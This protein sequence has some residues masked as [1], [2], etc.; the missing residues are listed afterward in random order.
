M[1]GDNTAPPRCCD[2]NKVCGEACCLSDEIC[3][4]G[5]NGDAS[6]CCEAGRVPCG[7]GADRFC[8]QPGESCAISTNPNKEPQCC[9]SGL[10][11]CD[12]E[13]CGPDHYCC[14]DQ[15]CCSN[16]ETVCQPESGEFRAYC[17]LPGRLPCGPRCCG[18]EPGGECCQTT[19][20]VWYCCAPN[21]R[22]K[23]TSG[24]TCQ[25]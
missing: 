15:T 14:D 13:C 3:H 6:I 5:V 16:D 9:E 24:Q 10:A 21:L 22:C 2:T 20:G 1:P 7:K 12:G 25:Q 18:P 11:T 19:T 17:C 4:P 8:C 23:L